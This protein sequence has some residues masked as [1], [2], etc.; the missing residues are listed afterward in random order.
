MDVTVPS[1]WKVEPGQY[2]YLWLPRAGL[3]VASQLPLCYVLS[4]E[5]T[6]EANN[7]GAP[8]SESLHL[9]GQRAQILASEQS[10]S[11]EDT[12][13]EAETLVPDSSAEQGGEGRQ[14]GQWQN[15][16]QLYTLPVNGQYREEGPR[17]IL[18]WATERYV[19]WPARSLQH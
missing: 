5:D 9:P 1:T 12:L 13:S 16:K 15:G 17:R 10:A 14:G 2:V 4:W 19:C 3:R 8:T 6:P 18:R 7:T 11:Q